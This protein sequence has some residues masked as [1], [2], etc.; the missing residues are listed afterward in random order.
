MIK[1]G[2]LIVIKSGKVSEYG[3]KS[4]NAA[5]DHAELFI[6]NKELIEKVARVRDVN[7]WHQ[8]LLLER[9]HLDYTDIV[10]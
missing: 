1:E 7:K 4:L 9:P 3:G 10:S 2:D 6:N 8:D 5:S